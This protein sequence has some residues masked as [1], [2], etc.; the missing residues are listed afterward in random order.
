MEKGE[1]V[2]ADGAKVTIKDFVIT[3][4]NRGVEVKDE[5]VPEMAP[6][7]VPEVA[8]EV[9]PDM[10]P[11]L[12]PEGEAVVTAME[13]EV[14]PHVAPHVAPEVVPHVVPEVAPEVVPGKGKNDMPS[15]VIETT[16]SIITTKE[17]VAM[18]VEAEAIVEVEAEAKVEAEAAFNEGPAPKEM[19]AALVARVESLEAK[20]MDVEA[21][22]EAR[23]DFESVA[24]TAIDTLAGNAVSNFKPEA[25]RTS[26]AVI[27]GSIFNQ[28]KQKAGLK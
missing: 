10:V 13:P 23:A 9:A 4:I 22:F 11:E 1:V 20:Y 6:D 14:V 2:F 21:K 8:P 26:E 25:K 27:K 24:A 15:S 18:E 17:T 16:E 5:V 7:M 12:T 3:D 28:L 19:I